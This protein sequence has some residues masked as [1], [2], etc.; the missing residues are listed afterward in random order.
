MHLFILDMTE[1]C[2]VRGVPGSEGLWEVSG[3]AEIETS[4]WRVQRGKA[5]G[6]EISQE[7]QSRGCE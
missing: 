4:I 5:T 6:M 7:S 3:H 2:N 1:G